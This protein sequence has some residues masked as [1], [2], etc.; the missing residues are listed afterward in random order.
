MSCHMVEPCTLDV[1]VTAASNM[2]VMVFVPSGT[3]I[4]NLD[5]WDVQGNM[6]G[7]WLKARGY[8]EALFNLLWFANRD[9]VRARYEDADESGM[10]TAG[11]PP[12][13]REV[14]IGGPGTTP[15][16]ILKLCSCFSYQSCDVETWE[17]S[18]GRRFIDSIRIAA[19]RKLPGWEEAAWGA[20]EDVVHARKVISLSRLARQQGGARAKRS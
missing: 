1:L 15:V 9:S 12:A 2:D 17:E 18:V 7:S 11:D 10:G 8:E 19:C 5:E 16:E 3:P 14:L 4:E 13:Y 20:E 6:R